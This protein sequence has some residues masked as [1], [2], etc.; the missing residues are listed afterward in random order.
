[1]GAGDF[2]GWGGSGLGALF[3]RGIPPIARNSAPISVA[4]SSS[5]TSIPEM[6][7]EEKRQNMAD[8]KPMRAFAMAC[9]CGWFSFMS[10]FLWGTS[11]VG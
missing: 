7:I 2:G 3:G 10:L 8:K 5:V 11:L 1:M 9:F 4:K 6:E